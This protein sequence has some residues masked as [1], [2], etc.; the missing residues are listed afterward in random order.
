MCPFCQLREAPPTR[1]DIFARWI[2]RLWPA[3][4]HFRIDVID[5]D[6]RIERSYGAKG[7]MGFVLTKPCRS[8]NNRWMSELETRAIPILTPMIQGQATT[9]TSES[10][11]TLAQWMIKTSI[12]FEFLQRRP[13]RYFTRGDRIGIYQNLAVPRMMLFLARYIPRTEPTSGWFHEYPIPLVMTTPE[14]KLDAEAYAATFAIG[15][16]V[17][18]VFTHRYRLPTVRFHTPGDWNDASVQVWPNRLGQ[19]K[20]WPPQ[21]LL[22]EENLLLF[23]RRWAELK[24]NA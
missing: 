24:P 4:G 13:R 23:S 22:D 2:A 6:G 7:N 14:G 9:L 20:N 10:C 16:L 18:Q 17:I 21:L 12:M 8:C 11:R 5:S 1:E 19:E 15:Q 3:G